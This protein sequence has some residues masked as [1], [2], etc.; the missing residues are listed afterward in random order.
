M[1]F[2]DGHS[3]RRELIPHCGFDLH[4]PDSHFEHFFHVPVDHLSYLENCLFRSSVFSNWVFVSLLL[5][6]M[7]YLCILD[8]NPL[9]FHIISK[10]FF[11]LVGCLFILLM[12]SFDVQKL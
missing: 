7:S 11:Y 12:I 9:S 4:L 6:H 1:F 8:I 3:D 10:Y 2:D 5:S